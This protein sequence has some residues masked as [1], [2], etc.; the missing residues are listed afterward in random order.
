MRY[1]GNY[2]NRQLFLEFT[3]TSNV[4]SINIQGHSWILKKLH[5]T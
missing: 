1:T 4:G 3:G 2:K 5:D